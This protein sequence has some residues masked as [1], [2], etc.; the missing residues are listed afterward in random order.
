MIEPPFWAVQYQLDS[1]LKKFSPIDDQETWHW[2]I[3]HDPAYPDNSSLKNS[4]LGTL[5]F[6]GI[7]PELWS[8]AYKRTIWAVTDEQLRRYLRIDYRHLPEWIGYTWHLDFGPRVIYKRALEL[9]LHLRSVINLEQRPFC[10][11]VAIFQAARGVINDLCL[12]LH[13]RYHYSI[14]RNQ[15]CSCK[16]DIPFSANPSF[17]P[18][19]I[20]ARY[21]LLGLCYRDLP[22]IDQFRRVV[23]TVL[24]NDYNT[25]RELP[26]SNQIDL[27]G[28]DLTILPLPHDI[29]TWKGLEGMSTKDIQLHE[30][31]RENQSGT[32]R[33]QLKERDRRMKELEKTVKGNAA[34]WHRSST[35]HS[36]SN[37]SPD[38]FPPSKNLKEE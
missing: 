20:C 27:S 24:T 4:T 9:Q 18:T 22:D 33:F 17:V 13:I 29:G 11:K 5:Y 21:C 10:T 30:G 12:Q 36:N 7:L 8:K 35:E 26:V 25:I 1:E 16:P 3:Q 37:D 31:Q 14:I 2:L 23:L 28:G 38:L 15:I 32:Y 34:K 6:E 19:F